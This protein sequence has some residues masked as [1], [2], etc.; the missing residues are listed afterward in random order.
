MS[1]TWRP[2]TGNDVMAIVAMAESHFQS[3]I[4]SIF[5][6]DP[7]AYARNITMAV[8]TQFYQ[9]TSE[10]VSVAE[11][12]EGHIRAYTWAKAF[13][14]APWS[15]DNMVNVCMAH[16]DLTLPARHRL[17][18]ITDML[19]IWENFAM[20]AQ[21]HIICSTTMRGDQAGF[22]KLHARHGYDV[23]GSYAYKRINP[24][25]TQAKPVN[26]LDPD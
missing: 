22:L 15:D 19:A 2:A 26:P 10:L 1:Y 11:D 23:R 18:L 4:D 17:A 7:T 3:E 8:V 20:F 5:T 9:P 14:R 24:A 21:H 16:V 25:A 6:P 12:A 13:Q